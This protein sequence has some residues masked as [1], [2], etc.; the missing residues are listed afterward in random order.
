MSQVSN[1]STTSAT[2]STSSSSATSLSSDLDSTAFLKLLV[3][4]LQNQDPLNPSDDTQF[5]SELAQFTSLEQMTAVSSNT[6][7]SNAFGLIG[8]T[9]TGLASDNKTEVQGVVDSV[10]TSSGTIYLNIGNYSIAVSNVES[11]S[12]TSTSSN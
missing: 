5:I 3:L 10:S 7:L 2:S 1:V 6:S 4:K 8:K 9:V 11:V 12:D